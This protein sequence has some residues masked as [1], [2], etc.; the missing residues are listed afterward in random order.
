MISVRETTDSIDYAK[1]YCSTIDRKF[2]DSDLTTD[3]TLCIAAMD[4]VNNYNGNFDFVLD[5]QDKS[6]RWTLSVGQ[7]RGALNVLRAEVERE[8]KISTKPAT[9]VQE[10]AA[11]ATS[12]PE[13]GL[14]YTVAWEDGTWTT[15][16]IT[17]T[18][19]WQGFEGTG[20]LCAKYL[21]GSDNETSFTG[22]AFIK[23]NGDIVVWKKFRESDASGKSRI[24]DALRVVCETE[25][26][27]EL[28]QLY[29]EKSGR[30][31]KCGRKLTVPASLHRGMGPICAKGGEDE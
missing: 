16:K 29:A 4:Y 9:T 5:L 15:I 3:Q 26:R 28:T 20:M 7:L 13:A 10:V 12:L 8:K 14:T 18:N 2:C 25:D 31:S 19:T 22:F 24:I 30:C 11:K 17:D 21:A 23:P 6:A 27:G 1:F